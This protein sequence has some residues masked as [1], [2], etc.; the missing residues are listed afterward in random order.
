VVWFGFGFIQT[1]QKK[2]TQ[3][4]DFYVCMY[5]KL[6]WMMMMMMG[7]VKIIVIRI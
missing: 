7:S 4:Y 6:V 2:C 3:L 1:R 5:I